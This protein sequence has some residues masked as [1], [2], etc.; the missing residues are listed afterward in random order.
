MGAIPCFNN[1]SPLIIT[2]QRQLKPVF[3]F[4]SFGNHSCVTVAT[5][6]SLGR[7]M[8]SDRGS[9]S[10]DSQ[11]SGAPIHGYLVVLGNNGSLPTGDKGRK[12]SK[13][14]VTQRPEPNGVQPA[15]QYRVQTPQTHQNP[16]IMTQKAVLDVYQLGRSS[17]EPIDFVVADTV[18]GIKSIPYRTS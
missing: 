14:T 16:A 10:G 18:P 2:F 13:Y 9:G 17:E 3:F 8:P 6:S 11:S 7:I 4:K 15:N 5:F 1:S 12:R